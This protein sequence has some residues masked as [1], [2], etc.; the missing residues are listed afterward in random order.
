[1]DIC[2]LQDSMIYTSFWGKIAQ[3]SNQEHAIKETCQMKAE[4]D[5]VL[6]AAKW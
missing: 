5:N 2:V 4:V 3:N 1:M 6:Y